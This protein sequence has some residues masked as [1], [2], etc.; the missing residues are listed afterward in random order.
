VKKIE[1]ESLSPGM[2]RLHRKTHLTIKKVTEDIE[3]SWHFNTAIAAVMELVNEIG[4]NQTESP[5]ARKSGEE[6]AVLKEA[7]EA[8]VMLLSPFVPHIAEELWITLGHKPSIFHQ[9][10]PTYDE[11]ATVAEE[12]EIPIQVNGKLRSRI[13]VEAEATDEEIK[14]AALADEKV[15]KHIAQREI[16]RT[17]IVPKRLINLVVK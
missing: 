9:S 11:E 6:V 16:K 10:W 15:Q 3:R 1:T 17:I 12:I 5:A 4:A 14:S 2:R 13:L 7:L 8:A